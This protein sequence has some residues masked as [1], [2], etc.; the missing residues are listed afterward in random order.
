MRKSFKKGL[1]GRTTATP[2]VKKK[3]RFTDEV[4]KDGEIATVYEVESFK[5]K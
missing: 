5:M 1:K 4:S 3:V 2:G